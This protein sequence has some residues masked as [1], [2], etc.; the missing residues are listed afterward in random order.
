MWP[1]TV[2][3]CTTFLVD[4]GAGGGRAIGKCYDW[5]LGHGLVVANARGRLKRALVLEPGARAAE[6][7]AEHASVT[8]NQYGVELPNGGMNDAGLV[9][10]I[11]WLD[12]TAL[13]PPDARPAVGE[14]QWI[15]Y[16]LD[17]YATT[18]DV[19]AHADELR[20]S[21]AHGRVHY[22][23]CDRAGECAAFEYVAGKLVVSRG[24]RALTNHTYAESA[25]YAARAGD[26]TPDGMGSLDRFV[27]A[28]RLAAKP[29]G[30]AA[31]DA[32]AFH[33]LDS[34]NNGDSQWHIVYD[35]A[36]LRVSFRTRGSQKVKTIELARAVPASCG[37]PRVLDVDTD[38]AGDVTARLHPYDERENA[39]VVERSLAELKALPPGTA[40]QV[41]HYPS[42][43]VCAP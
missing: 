11:M 23:V 35:P 41:A 31:A 37:P 18:A 9:V 13:P 15:Q 1:L 29:A 33:V 21:A 34:V 36:R 26:K 19:A 14:L 40:A 25:A 8:F 38:V 10:E 7:R 6:W 2:A 17:R 5:H 43:L 28:S 24:A 4:A 12:S 30:G 20:V 39:R 16:M 27:R 42:Q 32:W 3:L 22:L